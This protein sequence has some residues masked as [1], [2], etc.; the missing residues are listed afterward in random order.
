[1]TVDQFLFLLFAA[2]GLGLAVVTVTLRDLVR[3]A[4]A[5]IGCL[6]AVAG[7]FAM[8]EASLFVVAQVA[9][10]V[11]A[12]ATL[13][14][15]VVMLT[16]RSQR[17]AFAQTHR[18]A[19]LAAL[20]VAAP[21]AGIVWGISQY[22]FFRQTAPGLPAADDVLELGRALIDPQ[23]FLL[24]FE[25]VSVLLLSVLIGAVLI[26]GGAGSDRRARS[27]AVRGRDQ[28]S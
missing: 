3:S 10:Y 25:A 17:E 13:I 28:S 11:G 20:L 22:A 4:F 19:P 16:R 23:R 26:A 21:L 14:V 1:M 7:L 9:V 27:D 6:F 15:L 5:M 8:L 12:I 2:V 18:Y 24:P